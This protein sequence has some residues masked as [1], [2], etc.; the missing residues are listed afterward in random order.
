MRAVP[1]KQYRAYKTRI[2]RLHRSVNLP[3][4]VKHPQDTD[5]DLA[6]EEAGRLKRSL[7]RSIIPEI[8]SRAPGSSTL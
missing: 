6:G 8:S 7:C 5:Q 2:G 3:G 1:V 4:S